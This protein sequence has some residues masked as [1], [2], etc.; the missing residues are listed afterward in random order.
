M[1][2]HKDLATLIAIPFVILVIVILLG[3]FLARVLL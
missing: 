3:F 2:F 1:N